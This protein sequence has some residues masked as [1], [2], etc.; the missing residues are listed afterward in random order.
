MINQTVIDRTSLKEETTLAKK[1]STSNKKSS[2]RTTSNGQ[3]GSSSGK[4]NSEETD[5]IDYVSISEETRRRYLN[6]AM[7]VITSR[8]L[9]DVRDGL[10]PVQRRILYSMFHDLHLTNDAK[11]R[12]CAKICGDTVGNYHPHGD[13]AV[14]DALVRLAQDFSLKYPLISGQGNFGSVLG[15]PCAAARYTEA[16]LTKIAAHLMSELRY[17]TVAMRPNYEATRDEPVVFPAEYPNLLVNGTQGIAVG[18]ATNIPPHNLGEVIK[19]C[20]HLID[21][22]DSTVAV[23]LKY[24][25]GPDFPLGGRMMTDRR[26]MRKA[27]E[28]GKGTVK[29]RG[30]WKFDR[31]RRKEVPHRLVIHSVPYG[32]S[33]G[34]LVSDIGDIIASGKLPQLIDVS[35]ETDN[36]NGLRV[37]LEINKESDPEAVMAYLYK[38]TALEQNFSFNFTCLIPDEGGAVIP[39]RLSLVEM[40]QHFLDFRL[41]TVR[42]RFE[43]QLL[44]LQKRIHILEGLEIIFNGLDK[45]LRIIRKSKGKQDAAEKLM[46]AFPL[47]EIQTYA[48][49]E[50]Q[51]YRIS[52]LEINHILEEL[53]DKRKQAKQIQAILNS[54]SRLWKIVKTEL[55]EIGKLF[56][57]KRATSIGSVDE[58]QEFDPQAY[59]VRENT[60]VVVTSEGWIKRVGKISSVKSTRTREGD[61]VLAVV[62]TNTLEHIILFTSEGIAYTLPVQSIPVSSGYGDPLSKYVRTGDGAN[63]VAALSTDAR[64][65]PEDVSFRGQATPSPYLLVVTRDGQVMSI[66]LSSY[67]VPST[68]AGRKYCRLRKGDRVVLTE[69]VDEAET[70]FIASKQARIIHF[71][72]IEVPLLAS[73]G[74]GVK[75]IKLEKGDEVLGATQLTRP[76]DCLRVINSNDKQLNFGQMKYNVT[77]RGGKGTKTSMRNGF[78]QIIRPEIELIDWTEMEED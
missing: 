28:E 24:I 73:P 41:I 4:N 9:P 60:N 37:V 51:L 16:K 38:R 30:E 58:I 66:S 18:M 8:A 22:P 76:G 2:K 54:N 31:E 52:Q 35:D 43:Y 48:I 7:S 19:A 25:K 70:M 78:K 29:T 44:Q 75:G 34:P 64:F 13:T 23:L 46:H 42:K 14:Y 71:S 12:K 72:M 11:T 1:K 10:K 27:Y 15:L 69:I 21:S 50:L 59:I 32:V 17:Q 74:I 6:Y 53:A 33:T 40:L 20:V 3:G 77:S 68:K 63:I 45:A 47:D 26:T 5:R 55:I 61:T 39:A 57:Q 65:T 62:P 49:L 56:P 67:R 36:K